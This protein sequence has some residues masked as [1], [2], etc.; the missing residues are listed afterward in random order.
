[1]NRVRTV[2][3]LLLLAASLVACS[4]DVD[5][6]GNQEEGV[7]AGDRYVALG[8]S[9]TA[10]PLLGKASGP[11][12]CH[13]TTGNY[14]HLLAERLDLELVDGGRGGATTE[15]LTEPQPA[16]ADEVPPQ[17]DA[18]DEDT[19]LVTL[20]IGA[21]DGNVFGELLGSCV[22]L[23]LADPDSAPCTEKAQLDNGRLAQEVADIADKIEDAVGEILERAPRARVV[24][25]GYPQ[26]VPESGPCDQL[27]LAAGD[28]P[29][30]RQ[31]VKDIVDAQEDGARAADAEYV[32]VWSATEGHDVCADEPWVAGLEPQK[33]GLLLHPY[34]EHQDVVADLLV[35]TIS[36]S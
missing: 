23:G 1:V 6:S 10:G 20:S 36:G 33:P 18:L 26:I 9:Y 15:H 19:A 35:E 17:L 7:A 3:V 2:P 27:P 14:P 12:G 8:D 5:A 28:F 24:V 22:Q 34:A 29:F 11:D 31:I 16:G 25:V 4:E 21:N 13:Q 30:A 32:D